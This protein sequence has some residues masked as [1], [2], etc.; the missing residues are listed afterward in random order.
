MCTPQCLVET[1]ELIG[2]LPCGLI[3]LL[4]KGQHLPLYLWHHLDGDYSQGDEL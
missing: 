3:Y 1:C 4:W 2:G